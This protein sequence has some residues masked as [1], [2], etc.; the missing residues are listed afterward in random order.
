MR[1]IDLDG[2]LA[3]LEYAMWQKSK[4]CIDNPVEFLEICECR[5]NEV[6]RDSPLIE[7]NLN[8]LYGDYR[9][10]TSL[11]NMDRF[12]A[13]NGYTPLAQKAYDILRYNKLLWCQSIGIPR[14]NIIILTDR[15]QKKWYSNPNHT[16]YDDNAKTIE[17]WQKG[18]GNGVLIPYE[19]K[20][21]E[22]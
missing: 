2:V 21:L 6:F 5:C 9:I 14:E 12:F 19:R 13:V 15:S 16:L 20:F 10:L 22:V 4:T 1:Y 3:D 7:S 8:L 11:P 18:G 17:E